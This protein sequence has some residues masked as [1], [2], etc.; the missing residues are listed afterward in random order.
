MENHDQFYRQIVEC[1]PDAIGVLQDWRYGFV[2][3]AFTK[4]FGYSA[5]DVAA[6]L[7]F[8]NLL[9][10]EKREPWQQ[11][12]AQQVAEKAITRTYR[13][14]L[15]TKSGGR[16]PCDVSATLIAY[17]GRP[18]ELMMLRD[19]SERQS[20]ER[21]FQAHTEH[22]EKLMAQRTQ[23]LQA[24]NTQ[25]WQEIHEREQAETDARNMAR[26]LHT[27]LE[28]IGEGVTLSNESGVFDI[29]NPK[30][31]SLTGYTKAEA[32]TAADFLWLLYPDLP[33]HDRTVHDIQ[34]LIRQGGAH[35]VETV[36]HAKDG[37]AKALLVSTAVVQEERNTWFLSTYHDITTR[38]QIEEHLQLSLQEK[39]VLLKE[40]HHRV[41]N[42]LQ[43][44]ASLLDFQARY[45][46]DDAARKA[47]QESHYRIQSMAMV[48]ERLYRSENLSKIRADEYIRDL[49]HELFL[50][51]DGQ[52][53]ASAPRLQ[54]DPVELDADTAIGCGFLITELISNVLK[55]AFPPDKPAS[56][57]EVW[58]SLAAEASSMSMIVGD[59]GVGLPDDVTVGQTNTLG[60]RLIGMFLRQLHASVEIARQNGTTFTMTF[61]TSGGNAL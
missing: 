44:I 29:F 42:N 35:D 10:A 51:Y 21:A 7:S 11:Q 19:V 52:N 15:V 22:L 9:Q 33:G 30:M 36:I 34:T 20:V 49:V 38:K 16:I 54:I 48:H 24:I 57:P 13:L 45:A 27:V 6:G 39:D 5:E 43:V 40:V 4:I 53:V 14:D 3:Q 2:N 23:E 26:R 55:H 17:Q 61:Q 18:A 31:E 50:A 37:T 28:T 1:C 58:I 32:N 8:F 46:R 12:H 41:K 25:L 59:N 47:L 56:A 60:M